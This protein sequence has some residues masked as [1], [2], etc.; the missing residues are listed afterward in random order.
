MPSNF[1]WHFCLIIVRFIFIEKWTNFKIGIIFE[2][3]Q[4]KQ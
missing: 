1:G 3:N 4:Q 2:M